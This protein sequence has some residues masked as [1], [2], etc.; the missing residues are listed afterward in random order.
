M[1]VKNIV[2]WPDPVLKS[3]SEPVTQFND[4]LKFLVQDI[5]DTMDSEPMAGLAA[6]QIGVLKRVFVLD[7]PPEH[8]D[9]NGTNGKE[10]FINPEIY[11]KEG[12]FSWE[13][14]CMSVPGFRGKVTRANDIMVRYQN[15]HGEYLDKK[16]TSYLAGGIQHELDHLDG[17]LWVDY[18]SS[19][20][21]S[22]LKKKL[23]K[24]KNLSQDEIKEI[25]SRT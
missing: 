20:K 7:I 5:F 21:K 12:S 19:I 22:F 3:V 9:G 10:V 23:M 2:I 17:I 24:I 13:E 14:G 16:A 15:E 18:Q 1:A 4:E 25:R 8:N 6:P 11:Q